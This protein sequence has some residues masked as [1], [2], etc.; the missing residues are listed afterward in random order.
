MPKTMRKKGRGLPMAEILEM[1]DSR[2]G[3]PIGECM[4]P[5]TR[6]MVESHSKIDLQIAEAERRGAQIREQMAETERQ[7]QTHQKN[8]QE[9]EEIVAETSSTLVEVLKTGFLRFP[10]AF[11]EFREGYAPRAAPDLDGPSGSEGVECEGRQGPER[12]EQAYHQIARMGKEAR[13]AQA[14]LFEI[15]ANW[16]VLLEM[17]AELEDAVPWT[18]KSRAGRSVV[19]ALKVTPRLLAVRGSTLPAGRLP[20]WTVHVFCSRRAQSPSCAMVLG[21]R[22]SERRCECDVGVVMLR[23]CS[24]RHAVTY[25]VIRWAPGGR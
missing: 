19:R 16:R 18:L 22:S 25:N 10:A 14:R 2:T 5:V 17:R 4:E 11:E 12:A 13:R 20:H 15:R 6:V 9:A 7:M 21:Q 3:V 8:L 1:A 23:P 24:A